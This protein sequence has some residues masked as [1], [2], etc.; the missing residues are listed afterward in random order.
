MPNPL[1]KGLRANAHRDAMR[2]RSAMLSAASQEIGAPPEVKDPERRKAALA[3]YRVFL[4]TYYRHRFP[5]A[6]S[7]DHIR[8]LD[9]LQAAIEAGESAAI[10][11]P[12][13][14][15][16]TTML[17]QA[18][19]W[20]ILRGSWSFGILIAATAP[21]A[22]EL[23]ESLKTE[24]RTNDLLHEDFP[25][26]TH[27]IRA[28]NDEPRRCRG[29]RIAG[30][31]TGIR[32]APRMIRLAAV[33]D[34]GFRGGVISASGLGG[35]VRGSRQ[36]LA[37]GT[38]I[39]PD[40]VV[41]DDPQTDSSAR[42]AKQTRQR[43]KLIQGAIRGMAGPQGRV[44][45]FAAVTVIQ[46]DDLADQLLDP[47][48]TGWRA[49]RT[50]AL[51]A[52]PTHIELWHKYQEKRREEAA[53][54]ETGA[55]ESFYRTNREAMDAGAVVAWPERIPEGKQS[56]L[57]ACMDYHLDDPEAFA[58]EF[59]QEPVFHDLATRHIDKLKVAKKTN[60]RPRGAVPPTCPFVVAFIDT[61]D[62]AFFWSMM[63]F[64][65]DMTGFVID[66]GTWPE[67]SSRSFSLSTIQ[68]TL[69]RMY[70]GTGTDAAIM[71][72]GDA[73]VSHL[74]AKR[75]PK[76][77]GAGSATVD[78]VMA[79][80]GYKPEIWQALKTKHRAIRLTR[81]VGIRAAGKPMTEWTRR[82]GEVIGN[83]WLMPPAIR[84]EHPVTQIDTNHWKSAVI[85]AVCTPTGDKGAL[86]FFGDAGTLHSLYADHLDA[87]TFVETEGW[88]RKVV[89]WRPKPGDHDNHWLDCTVGCFVAASILGA[90]QDGAPIT[91]GRQRKRY[92]QADLSVRRKYGQQ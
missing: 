1:T 23:L 68:R 16:K 20:A 83:H 43:M 24:L 56:A 63:A 65:Q 31:L 51:Y 61:H 84:R 32:W 81:G 19:L 39:R 60:G 21:K 26:A 36:T 38:T 12:R 69:R 9:M 91:Q 30:K 53:L 34:R 71:A 41:L 87:E 13:G 15:G 86:S 76:G 90:H 6:W 14:S 25:E 47:A 88:G 10:A 2:I 64:Q 74:L 27:P 70:P 17:E 72:G 78:L 40:G 5:L 75:L 22:E 52:F 3:N 44:S 50:K 18:P 73:L 92:T 29:Q 67:Q 7:K 82:P 79:D 33:P 66:Y 45:I 48:K 46:P 80:T 37:D 62:K 28:L 49:I 77:S 4:E 42:S 8:A 58:A 89:E 59:Q 35:S 55:A 54:G 11:M 57:Q 85:E